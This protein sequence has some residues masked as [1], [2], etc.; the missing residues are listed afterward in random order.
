MVQRRNGLRCR[1]DAAGVM[2]VATEAEQVAPPERLEKMGL[3]AVVPR[4]TLRL[5]KRR[6][7]RSSMGPC[8]LAMAMEIC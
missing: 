8:S 5:R 7:A 1:R 6:R 2:E 4:T 3:V